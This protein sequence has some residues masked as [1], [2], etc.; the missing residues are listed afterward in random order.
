MSCIEMHCRVGIGHT[1]HLLCF[2]LAMNECRAQGPVPIQ[3]LCMSMNNLFK[4]SA[5]ELDCSMLEEG[6]H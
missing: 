4:T 5:P 6:C 2:V 1:C 3:E